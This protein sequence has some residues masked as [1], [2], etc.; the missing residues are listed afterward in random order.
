MLLSVKFQLQSM[1]KIKQCYIFT[2]FITFI[3]LQIIYRL[4]NIQINPTFIFS[5]NLDFFNLYIICGSPSSLCVNSN[6]LFCPFTST[7]LISK[8]HVSPSI[9][10]FGRIGTVPY[11]TDAVQSS[12]SNTEQTAYLTCLF[13]LVLIFSILRCVYTF[14]VL[15][16][17]RQKNCYC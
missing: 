12:F 15:Y 4:L 14:F 2:H 10:L 5:S 17:L 6:F 3:H 11:S 1:W 9:S 8:T 13:V 7:V 16:F